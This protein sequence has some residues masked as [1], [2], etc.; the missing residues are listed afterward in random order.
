LASRKPR[1]VQISHCERFGK[2]HGHNGLMQNAECRMQKPWKTSTEGNEADSV[3]GTPTG[4]TGTV[5]LPDWGTGRV[6]NQRKW[7]VFKSLT[8]RDLISRT[9][10]RGCR[11]EG[12]R[13]NAE[14][15]RFAGRRREAVYR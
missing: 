3:G 15:R 6:R 4:A 10:R 9:T 11:N 8:V 14:C 12:R 2:S 7:A 13:Q 5:A 1:R